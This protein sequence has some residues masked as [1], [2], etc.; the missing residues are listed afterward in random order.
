[1]PDQP[2][3]A[4]AAVDRAHL[5][6]VLSGLHRNGYGHLAR[7]LDPERSDMAGQL[8][9]AGAEPPLGIGSVDRGHVV[10]LVAAPARTGAATELMARLGA[11]AVWEV[12]RTGAR[13]P[14]LFGGVTPR[15]RVRRGQAPPP[16]AEQSAD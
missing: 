9:R 14:V 7:V 6:A 12:E 10:V 16:A 3:I 2:E 8:R 11:S 13:T 4:L 5:S 1:M 15:A